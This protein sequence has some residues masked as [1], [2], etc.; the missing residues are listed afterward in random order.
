MKIML[1]DKYSYLRFA[2]RY[3]GDTEA[4][5]RYLG[6]HIKDNIDKPISKLEQILD[7]IGLS[8][9]QKKTLVSAMSKGSFLNKWLYTRYAHLPLADMEEFKN[10]RKLIIEMMVNP[11]NIQVYSEKA[12]EVLNEKLNKADEMLEITCVGGYVLALNGIRNTHDIDAIYTENSKVSALIHDVG[13][14]LNINLQE[15]DWLNCHVTKTIEDTALPD[16]NDK[17]LKYNLSNLKVYVASPLYVLGMKLNST[18][19]GT[20][21]TDG[22]DVV[23][24]IKHNPNWDIQEIY[25]QLIKYKFKISPID[26]FNAFFLALDYDWYCEIT[27]KFG[28]NA[29]QDFIQYG[30][31]KSIFSASRK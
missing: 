29:L 12:F 19:S 14:E 2:A 20:R 26:L 13:E 4:W 25:A 9:F 27:Q 3:A 7:D 5:F 21:I 22:D 28:A 31:F 10:R 24:L 11:R 18:V 8:V 6:K 15:K 23:D 17:I 30:K 1:N 16:G